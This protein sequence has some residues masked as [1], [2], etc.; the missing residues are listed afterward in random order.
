VSLTARQPVL[1]VTVRNRGRRDSTIETVA[2]VIEGG[3][4]KVNVFDD[5]Q[6]SLPFWLPAE[7]SHVLAMGQ[8]GGYEHGDIALKRFNVVDGAGRI[9]LL[10]ERL[11]QRLSR[12]FRRSRSTPPPV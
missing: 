1:T 4:A 7:R 8:Q 12:L 6:P 9:H 11:R 3:G 5:L 2:Q 10:S